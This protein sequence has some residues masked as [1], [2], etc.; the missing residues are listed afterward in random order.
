MPANGGWAARRLM[1]PLAALAAPGMYLVYKYNQYRRQ[2][3][4]NNRRKVTERELQHL[5][6]KI[7]STSL[8]F[9]APA[10]DAAATAAATPR[11]LG[12]GDGGGL[13]W[14]CSERGRGGQ[15]G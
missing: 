10:N 5:N 9:L 1:R 6:H 8:C 3:Q 14:C 12:D 7:V 15:V 2:V 4:E 13:V 11:Y